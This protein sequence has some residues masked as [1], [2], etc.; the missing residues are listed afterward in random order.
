MAGRLSNLTKTFE[1]CSDEKIEFILVH[2]EQD[3]DTQNEI[4]ALQRHFK[5]LDIQIYRKTLMSPG[6]ARN[7]G[8]KEITGTWFCF[9]DSDD[10]PQICNISRT[11]QIADEMGA[12]VAIGNLITI[13][14][15]HE[16]LIK[17]SFTT[18]HNRVS[19]AALAL[20]PGFTRFVFKSSIFRHIQFP[21]IKMGEDQVYL[22]RTNFLNFKIYTSE[23]L[24]YK[25][26]LDVPDQATKNK[27]SLPE[28]STALYLINS[29]NANSKKNMK[30]FNN[31]LTLKIS[32][33][34]IYRKIQIKA[35]TKNLIQSM[36]A[37]PLNSLFLFYA[38]IRA[39]NV[40]K[41]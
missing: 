10:L 40:T 34:C 29:L 6:L 26:F 27:N 25:Y 31:F 18:S 7:Y 22:A 20:N 24:L 36:L 11:A 2:D 13:N 15:A 32:V 17:S 41:S 23:L 33:T 35:A 9:S 28:L 8:M 21:E 37:S 5:Y 14:G 1:N 3:T 38:I 16:R 30:Q 19:I 39:K 12:D 4:E